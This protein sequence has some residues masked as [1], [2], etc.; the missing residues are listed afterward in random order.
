M[1]F[2]NVLKTIVVGGVTYCILSESVNIEH[3]LNRQEHVHTD[4][5]HLA[6][7][8]TTSTHGTLAASAHASGDRI[9][10]S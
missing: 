10:L 7:L 5:T 6:N 8:T 2:N 1:H 3:L 9:F 4:Y